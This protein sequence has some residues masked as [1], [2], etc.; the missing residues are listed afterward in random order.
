MGVAGFAGA[1]PL[2]ALGSVPLR[3]SGAGDLADPII[4]GP[5]V[6]GMVDFAAI[7]GGA[8]SSACIALLTI[9]Y[10]AV[11]NSAICRDL[12]STL[13][14][15]VI[16]VSRTGVGTAPPDNGPREIAAG[17]R[18]PWGTVIRENGHDRSSTLRTSGAIDGATKSFST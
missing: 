17:Q 3:A 5:D 7:I 14:V 16:V 10:P 11:V 13:A 15:R 1:H 18:G 8:P 4:E 9:S 6:A 2:T 12:A